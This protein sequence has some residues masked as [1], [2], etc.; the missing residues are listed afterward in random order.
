MPQYRDTK[1]GSL[2]DT[3]NAIGK[4]AFVRFYYDFK[5][6]TILPQSPRLRNMERFNFS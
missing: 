6:A 3:L 4:A 2:E 1:Y 5:D